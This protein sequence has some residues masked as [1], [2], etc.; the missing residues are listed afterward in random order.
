L[1][2]SLNL[3]KINKIAPR[4]LAEIIFE[5][6]STERSER[7]QKEMETKRGQQQGKIAKK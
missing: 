1:V 2:T 4:L 5:Q 6:W 3:Q 7:L